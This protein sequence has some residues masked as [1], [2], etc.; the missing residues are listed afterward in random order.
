MADSGAIGWTV[1]AGSIVAVNEAIFVPAEGGQPPDFSSVWRL[2]PATA[3]LAIGLDFVDRAV[4]G[5]GSGIAKLLV[6]AVLVFPVGNAPTPLANAA[7]VVS[8]IGKAS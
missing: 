5:F 7:K 3:L 8:G 6:F 1:A 2:V 4:P